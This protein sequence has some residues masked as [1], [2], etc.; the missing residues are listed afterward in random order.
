VLSACL[1]AAGFALIAD[2][3]PAQRLPESRNMVLLAHHGLHG[4]SAYQPVIHGQHGRWIAYVGHHGGAQLN[5]L[6]GRMEPNGTS[7]LDV[8]DPTNP[9]YLSHVPVRT[10]S[11]AQ[12]VRICNGKDL[13]DGDG[14]K[15]YM[16]RSSGQSSHEV[17]DVTTPK[18]PV[19]LVAVAKDLNGT[20]KS[21]WECDT[22]IAYLVSGLPGW[23][24]HRMSQVYDLANPARPVFI[25][26]FGLPGQQPGSTG[27]VPTGLHGPISTGPR[28]N[29]VYFGHGTNS[30]GILQI[31]DREKLLRGPREPT[32]QNLLYPEVGRF[33]LP[34][35]HGAHTVFPVM[36]VK[37]ADPATGEPSTR[38]FVVLTN[39]ASQKG[40]A[41]PRQQVWIVD[42]TAESRPI[43][44]TQWT[45]NESGSD[46]CARGG[47]VGSHSSHEN[48]TP[49]YYGR[50]MF[51][52]HFNAGV[53]AVD[54]RNPYRPQEIAYYVPAADSGGVVA[55]NNVEVDDRGYIYIVD[56]GSL[57]LH[58]LELTGEARRAANFN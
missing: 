57:G 16:L 46:Y 7:V 58:V 54:I 15:V 30:D 20:H 18:E 45:V 39:E 8:T 13:P 31:V 4:R 11:G 1:C 12:M 34:A 27:P 24:T 55:T 53:R 33:T 38:D 44:V 17:W 56:R 49:I 9:K 51:I 2:A 43:A 32:R 10:G 21:W 35:D 14:G 41:G 25:R 26:N 37:T 22:G 23:R 36:G 29:R 48:F 52:A 47:R 42:V 5:P 40:C 50:V 6:T 19:F 28:G 3:V